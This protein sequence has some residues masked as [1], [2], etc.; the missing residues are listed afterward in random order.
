M[1]AQVHHLSLYML[2]EAS[3]RPLQADTTIHSAQSIQLKASMLNPEAASDDCSTSNF[4]HHA[5]EHS[6]T[7]SQ[8]VA[9][10]TASAH[11]NITLLPVLRSKRKQPEPPLLS[12]SL[13]Q[14]DPLKKKAGAKQESLMRT[15]APES[16]LQ[17]KRKSRR[18]PAKSTAPAHK[19]AESAPVSGDKL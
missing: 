3:A 11:T 5:L 14:S 12:A 8:V 13:D 19:S 2:A 18:K 15:S 16:S 1:H 17:N 9:E 6:A 10:Q 7:S 4:Q